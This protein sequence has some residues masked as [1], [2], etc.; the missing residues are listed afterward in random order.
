MPRDLILGTAGHIDH[1]K[2]S[3]VKALTGIDCDR[4]PEEKQRGITIDIGF[5]HLDLGDVRLGVVDVPGHE[6]FIRNMLAG[7]AGIDLALLVVAADDSV[8]P[9]TREHLEILRLL[10][11]TRGAIALTKSDLVDDTTRAVSELEIREL[12][13]GT[14][15][16]D[17]PIV[18][19]SAMTGQG[20]D[21]LKDALREAARAV[22]ARDGNGWFR[23]AIDRAFVLQGHGSV[24]TGSVSSGSVRVGDELEWQ[25]GDGATE[26]VRA[27]SLSNHGRPVEE[28]HRGQRGAINLAGVPLEAIRRGQELATPG[29]LRP[30][31]VLTVRLRALADAR[32]PI[33]HRLPVRVHLGAAEAMATVS[34]LDA[35]TVEPGGAALAQL[36]LEEPVTAVWGQPYVVRDSSAERTLGGGN[37]LQPVAVK[38]RRRHLDSLVRV[39]QLAS[40]DMATRLRSAAWFAGTRGVDAGELVRGAGVAVDAADAMLR[41]AVADGS[42]VELAASTNRRVLV[43]SGRVEEL[44]GAVLGALGILH[45]QFP[46]LTT[47]DRQKV[48]TRLDYAGDEA[49]LHAVADRLIAR[50]RVVGDSRRIARADFKPKLSANQRKLKDTIVEAHAAAGFA[51]PEPESF[52]NRAG[53]N[54]AALKDIFEVAVAEGFLVKIA[55]DLYLHV[56]REREMRRL[57]A[58]RLA[59]PPGATVGEIRDLLGTTR[60]YAVPLCEHLDRV[61]ITRRNGDLRELAVGKGSNPAASG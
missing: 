33:K 7:A 21:R 11:I 54:A 17:A 43:H 56:D 59:K 47:H 6:K 53:G 41:D 37:V 34:L 48:L 1:G 15:L 44:E 31:K 39:E 23:M 58:E 30:S 51:P 18:P 4:L 20:I 28:L 9:Q 38:L 50:K 10:G 40:D 26:V 46:L 29:Y 36:F 49:I 52:A 12:V 35:D 13:K 16:E 45:E 2:T 3:L 24:V 19:V 8:M 25:R 42:I 22:T 5:A 27:R 55:E 32:R 60:K 57:V 61:G 14:F